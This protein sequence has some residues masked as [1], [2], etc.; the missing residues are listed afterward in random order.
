MSFR[1]CS[2]L[3]KQGAINLTD[4]CLPRTLGTLQAHEA[5]PPGDLREEIALEI[6]ARPGNQPVGNLL[7]HDNVFIHSFLLRIDVYAHSF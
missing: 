4:G 3:P 6:K 5:V 2:S 7:Q 1:Q